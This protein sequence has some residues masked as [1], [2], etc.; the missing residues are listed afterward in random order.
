MLFNC[1]RPLAIE[2]CSPDHEGV[3]A[4]GGRN[5]KGEG[6]VFVALGCF[7]GYDLI[8]GVEDIDCRGTCFKEFD[9]DDSGF[10]NECAGIRG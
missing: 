1:K 9:F 10:I 4:F 7:G 8:A 5:L 3:A 6:F 2:V